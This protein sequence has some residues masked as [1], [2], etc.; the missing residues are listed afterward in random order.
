MH[1]STTS[2]YIMIALLAIASCVLVTEAQVPEAQRQ[3]LL[4]MAS[5]YQGLRGDRSMMSEARKQR[6]ACVMKKQ[7]GGLGDI[8]GVCV[9]NDVHST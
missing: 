9:H 8:H 7:G 5:R 6:R 3:A 2:S 1:S 4:S